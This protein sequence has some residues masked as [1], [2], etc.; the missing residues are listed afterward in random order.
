MAPLV[1]ASVINPI[2]GNDG[3]ARLNRRAAGTSIECHELAKNASELLGLSVEKA[4]ADADVETPA[5]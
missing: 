5:R 1:T 2:L 4:A 3:S